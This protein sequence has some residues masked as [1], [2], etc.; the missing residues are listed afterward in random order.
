VIDFEAIPTEQLL[1]RMSTLPSD[2]IVLFQFVPQAPSEQAIGIYD[3]LA[4]ISQRF[5]PTVFTI[6]ALIM[7]RLED[8]TRVT[9]S[10]QCKA[11]NSLPV[12]SRA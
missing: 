9:M 8:G 10:R 4:A 12:V 2:T 6:T 3:V 7:E 11:V 5:P 1:Q